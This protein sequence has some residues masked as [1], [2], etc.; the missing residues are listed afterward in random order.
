MLR[1]PMFLDPTENPEKKLPFTV[2]EII[3]L[4]ASITMTNNEGH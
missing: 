4:K 3:L 1:L 2:A